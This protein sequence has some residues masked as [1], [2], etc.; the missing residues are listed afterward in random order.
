MRGAPSSAPSERQFRAPLGA[1]LFVQ[2]RPFPH[3]TLMPLRDHLQITAG[4][5]KNWAIAQMQDSL[6]VGLLWWIGLYLLKVPWAPLWAAL[7][8]ALQII[9]HIG[10]VL[11]LL[12]PASAA[13]IHHGSP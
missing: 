9:P 10:P 5:L 11:S 2:A 3:P 13:W 8:A 1:A 12:G 4:A 7:A 6:A